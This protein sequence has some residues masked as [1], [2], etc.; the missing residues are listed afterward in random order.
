MQ[1]TFQMDNT[2]LKEQ[3]LWIVD[4]SWLYRLEKLTRKNAFNA[5]NSG[6]I[7]LLENGTDTFWHIE[8]VLML[9]YLQKYLVIATPNLS[10][11][12]MLAN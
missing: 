5:W 11:K 9:E 10:R 6:I 7:S 2:N 1:L 4:K 3:L 8:A 12:A